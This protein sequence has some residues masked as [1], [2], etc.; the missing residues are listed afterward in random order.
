MR[1]GDG[2]AG[3]HPHHLGEHLGPLD[4]GDARDARGDELG[5]VLGD[6]GGVDDD[7]GPGHVLGAVPRREDRDAEGP[8]PEGLLPLA[9]VRPGD[10]Q[11]DAREDLGE[12]GHPDPPD[13]DEVDAADA[14]EVHGACCETLRR[15]PTAIRSARRA[16]PP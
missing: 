7:V 2:D 16:E 5:V 13:P 12:A 14:E 10:G 3:L 11:A 9:Q 1:A 4:D 15:I 8:E 6:G